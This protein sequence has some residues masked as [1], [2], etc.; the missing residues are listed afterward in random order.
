MRCIHAMRDHSLIIATVP[1]H[2]CVQGS[3]AA[4]D[5]E[6][7]DTHGVSDPLWQSVYAR[8][9]HR[10]EAWRSLWIAKQLREMCLSGGS[11]AHDIII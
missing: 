6:E 4:M 5:S 2:Q 7:V 8:P 11:W 3:M 9:N 1:V 10:T